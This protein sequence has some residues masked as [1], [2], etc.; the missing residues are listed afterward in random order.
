[1]YTL[2]CNFAHHVGCSWM[3]K[4]LLIQHSNLISV[5]NHELIPSECTVH[6]HALSKLIDDVYTYSKLNDALLQ[7]NYPVITKDGACNIH[8]HIAT[9]IIILH[10]HIIYGHILYNCLHY[11]VHNAKG[12]ITKEFVGSCI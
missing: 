2:R 11:N 8:A 6:I 12:K 5:H 7:E 1:M 4:C 10:T 9:M 3:F